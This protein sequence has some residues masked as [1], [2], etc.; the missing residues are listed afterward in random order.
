M[1]WRPTSVWVVCLTASF[2]LLTVSTCPTARA[3]TLG[4]GQVDWGD[5]SGGYDVQNSDWG[6]VTVS[7]SLS[8]LGSLA[9]DGFGGYYGYVNIVTDVLGGSLNNW[10]VQNM[11]M[12]YNDVSELGAGQ[13]PTTAYFSL[14]QPIGS[15]VTSL[16]Y[17]FTL[18]PTPLTLQPSGP[19]TLTSVANVT[20]VDG[21]LTDGI[22]P[23]NLSRAPARNYFGAPPASS[24]LPGGSIA[25]ST[26]NIPA[27]AEAVNHCAPGS[28]ARSLIYLSRV[29]P[30]IVI[31]QS[32]QQ[33][34]AT[35]TNLM[36]QA[37]GFGPTIF[38]NAIG[39]NSI[40]NN[41]TNS[42]FAV[43]KNM[44]VAT[45][46]LSIM[47]LAFSNTAL[48]G[49]FFGNPGSGAFLGAI[50]SLNST[51]DV[52]VWLNWGTITNHNNSGTNFV[53]G[54][55][56]AFVT[57]IR[58][59]ITSSGIVGY[60]IWYIDDPVQGDTNAENSLKQMTVDFNGN[61]LNPGANVASSGVVGF[62]IEQV[63][64]PSVFGLTVLGAFALALL[65]RRRRR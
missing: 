38:T 54:A 33:V 32:P 11:L 6:Q 3:A 9:P 36:R 21:I 59:H 19:T 12:Y 47:P 65:R 27:I 44:F 4:F 23:G 49:G 2:A 18:S 7:L 26:T 46:G 45:N 14:G 64:E 1:N 50:N 22:I 28:V 63:P 29:N 13:L 17:S 58:P 16:D 53:L 51:S 35:L 8:D 10:A 60:T 34:Y 52:E 48:F 40:S 56:Q 43:G 30:S 41:V 37:P 31:T 39:S 57:A 20:R 62:F 15:D 24:A 55:H 42:T 5:G 25:G 61:E